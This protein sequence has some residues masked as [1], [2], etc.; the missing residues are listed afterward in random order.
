MGIKGEITFPGDKSIS[1]R[2]LMFAALADGE[3][4]ISNLSTGVDVQ[5]TRKCLE[6]CGIEIRNDRNDVI[7]KGRKFSDPTEPLDCGNSGT[8]TRLLLGLLAG[9]GINATFVGDKSLSVR[10]MNRILEP[11]F[12]MGLKC[13]S[14]DGKLPITIKNSDLNGIQYESRVASAQVK[15]AILLAGLGASGKT[16]VKEPILSRDHTEKMINGLGVDILIKGLTATVSN[17]STPFSS[18]QFSIPGDPSTAAFFAASAALVPNSEIV[19]NRV[20]ANPTRIGFFVALEKMGV[21]M[22]FLDQWDEAGEQIGNLKIFHQALNNTPITIDNIPGLIDEIPIIAILATQAEGKMEIRGA[23]ELRIKECDRIH[24]ICKN[25]KKMG[26]DIQELDDGFIINGPT[27]LYG[28]KIETF[29]D[30][31]IAMAFAIAELVAH[32]KMVLDHP[33]CASISYPEFYDE[34]ERMIQ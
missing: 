15:S 14:H 10:P 31:R 26:A 6:S 5:S 2:A 3:S 21:G 23:E 28:A 16:S 11:L 13:E 8:T 20:L 18:F 12:Q 24:A 1:H 9:Q 22:E 4:R 19:L 34:L 25:L 33:E 7:V 30:H 17:L 32:G 27:P 29:H